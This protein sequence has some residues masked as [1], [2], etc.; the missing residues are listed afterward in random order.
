MTHLTS[1]PAPLEAPKKLAIPIASGSFCPHFGAAEE[2]CFF[3]GSA[4]GVRFDSRLKAPK[5]GPGILPMWLASQGVDAV[6]AAA[7]GE[8]ALLML[9]DAGIVAFHA[10]TG[11]DLEQ[12][13]AAAANGWLERM[14]Q[15][16]SK[17]EGHHHDCH[18]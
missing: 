4:S 7:M 2:F 10:G 6:V 16:N 11:I 9:A 1:P 12:L 5:H 13:A 8:R 14:N 17:C 3:L 15:T 18:H